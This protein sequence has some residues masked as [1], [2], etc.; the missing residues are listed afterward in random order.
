VPPNRFHQLPVVPAV[1]HDGIRAFLP[2]DAQECYDRLMRVAFPI[3]GM[4]NDKTQ[5]TNE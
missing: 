3:Q 1:D 2:S 5:M 4:T